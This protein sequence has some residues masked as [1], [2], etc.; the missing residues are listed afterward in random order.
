[1]NMDLKD[2]IFRDYGN[3]NSKKVEN[4][5]K[6]VQREMAFYMA[7]V[8]IFKN[9]Y[10]NQIDSENGTFQSNPSNINSF[11]LGLNYFLTAAAKLLFLIILDQNLNQIRG[12]LE[13]Y[14]EIIPNLF[15][16]GVL[17]PDCT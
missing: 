3:L 2:L 12:M 4:K 13:S 14:I 8:L 15:P 7:R 16:V 11:F 6:F 17:Y 1:M 10:D 5:N 9:K